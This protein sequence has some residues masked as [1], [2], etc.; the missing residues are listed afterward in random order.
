MS[1]AKSLFISLF[2]IVNKQTKC[3]AQTLTFGMTLNA[4]MNIWH[5][6]LLL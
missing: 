6:W 2:Y 4:Y 5:L 1:K 3:H